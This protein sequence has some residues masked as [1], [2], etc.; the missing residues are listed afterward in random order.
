MAPGPGELLRTEATRFSEEE[1]ARAIQKVLQHLNPQ[2]T[3]EEPYLQGMLAR[4]ADEPDLWDVLFDV[5]L[6][7]LAQALELE[8]QP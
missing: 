2:R 6:V 1:R 8:P 5:Y 4:L 7:H 3:S